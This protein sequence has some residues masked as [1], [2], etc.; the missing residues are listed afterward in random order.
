MGSTFYTFRML[1]YVDKW[2]GSDKEYD[3]IS[4]H[5]VYEDSTLIFD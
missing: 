2:G 1:T 4:I 5:D 3:V